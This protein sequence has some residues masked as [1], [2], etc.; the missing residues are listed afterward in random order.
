MATFLIF[1]TVLVCGTSF[2]SAG[3]IVRLDS[4]TFEPCILRNNLVV[5]KLSSSSRDILYTEFELAANISHEKLWPYVFASLDAGESLRPLKKYFFVSDGSIR[6]F[7]A[8][9]QVLYPHEIDA[10]SIL[11]FAEQVYRGAFPTTE[12]RTAKDIADQA[13]NYDVM[14]SPA[15]S[16]M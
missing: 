12:L 14:V 16:I 4:E 5:L 13:R 1:I 9:N 2:A 3:T 6:I 11:Y 15:N 8:G 7:V 10:D